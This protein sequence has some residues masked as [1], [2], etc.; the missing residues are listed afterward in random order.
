[1]FLHIRILWS[2]C[3]AKEIPSNPPA[4]L[5]STF[6]TRFSTEQEVLNA[7][8]G[9]AL[10]QPSLVQVGTSIPLTDKSRSA[11]QIRQ[12]KEHILEYLQ[13]CIAKFGLVQWAPDLRQSA[14]SLY[15]SACRIIALDTFKQAIIS[16]AYDF[17]RPNPVYLRDMDLLL[18]VYDHIVHFYLLMRYTRECM[19]PGTVRAK[20]DANPTYRNRQRVCDKFSPCICPEFYLY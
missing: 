19:A 20:D 9:N 2:L 14:Y 5:L 8:H 6:D 7:R 13:G 12:V 4:E 17:L 3:N 10:I 1:M 15:N 18:K 11:K 16:H